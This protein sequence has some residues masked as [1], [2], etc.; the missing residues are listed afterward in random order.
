MTTEQRIE[1]HCRSVWRDWQAMPEH[2]KAW[3]RVTYKHVIEVKA[4]EDRP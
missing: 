3:W 4:E 1:A 2:E